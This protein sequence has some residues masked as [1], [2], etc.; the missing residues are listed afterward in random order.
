ME[1]VCCICNEKIREEEVIEHNGKYYCRNCADE[2]LSTCASCG[3]TGLNDDMYY[4]D[5]DYYCESCYNDLF[6]TCEE[7]EEV[8]SVDDA[9]YY[10]GTPYCDECYH[11]R[12]TTCASCDDDYPNSVVYY[13][14]DTDEYYC[15]EC[16][17]RLTSNVIK[18]Y[19]ER[20]IALDFKKIASDNTELYLGFELEVE[21]GG[22]NSEERNNDA[23]YIRNH[24]SRLGLCFECDGSLNYGFEIISQP[25]T[26]N[27][28]Y[29]HKEDF[30]AILEYLNDRG[31]QSHNGGRC[32]LHVHISKKAFGET[33]SDVLDKNIKKLLL[34]TETYK[35]ELITFS[36]RQDFHYCEFISSKVKSNYDN[37]NKDIYY[38]SGEVL[39]DLN[40][41]INRY[42]VVNLE[43][44]NTI[45]LRVFRGTLKFE[46]FMA[47]LEFVN[48]LVEVITNKAIRKINFDKVVTHDKRALELKEYCDNKGICNSAYM[49]DESENVKKILNKRYSTYNNNIDKTAKA[50]NKAYDTISK[51]L[52]SKNLEKAI[53]DKDKNALASYGN[54]LKISSNIAAKNMSK[55]VVDNNTNLVEVLLDNT[56]NLNNKQ[57]L[58][59][60]YQTMTIDNLSYI[61]SQLSEN[62]KELIAMYDSII[63]TL[64]T[65]VNEM[66]EE[67][68]DSNREEI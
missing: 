42:Q 3:S 60:D 25:M 26:M 65:I 44:S 14:N 57:R 10:E 21:N 27:Y 2:K 7:C 36:R 6:V 40:K 68:E 53:K 38:K 23:S 54:L 51:A 1:K 61:R 33:N 15:E 22:L 31:Y 64:T 56:N 66:T 32:G 19:H 9:Y 52:E 47:T 43:N 46:T 4:V 39:K 45:E 63:N 58:I 37:M 48:S 62:D 18:D 12:Y 24:F 50:Y 49:V 59:Y 29:E 17:N 16:Y 55:I 13:D 28:I 35:N 5:G 67:L 30:K 11:N 20:D 8:I 41:R 34:F